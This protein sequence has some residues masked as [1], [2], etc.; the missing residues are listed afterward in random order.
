MVTRPDGAGTQTLC[1]FPR[2][3]APFVWAPVWSPDSN[4]LLLN[5]IANWNG[6][7]VK[8]DLLDFQ[9]HVLTSKLHSDGTAVLGW[10]RYAP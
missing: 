6:W 4:Q 2:R 8:I 3:H 5:E 7:K 1:A 10:A 9:T